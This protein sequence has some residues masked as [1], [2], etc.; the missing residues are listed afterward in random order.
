MAPMEPLLATEPALLPSRDRDIRAI[1]WWLLDGLMSG[2]VEPR[3]ASVVASVLRVM[4]SLGPEP[5]D[6]REALAEVELRG[7]LMH[8]IPPATEEQWARARRTFGTEFL[9]TLERRFNAIGAAPERRLPDEADD[10]FAFTPLG[11]G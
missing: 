4:A 5:M 7:L 10:G 2:E 11:L 8:G 9:E 1:G 3:T 6:E